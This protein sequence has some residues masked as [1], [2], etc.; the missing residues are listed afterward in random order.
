MRVLHRVALPGANHSS[1]ARAGCVAPTEEADE[2]VAAAGA[3]ETTLLRLVERREAGEPLAWVTGST[4]FLGHPV[5][6]R[7]G[8]YVPRWQTEALAERAIELLPPDGA[9]AD[10][11]TGSGSDRGGAPARSPGGEGGGHR[12]RP[13]GVPVRR[14]ERGRGLLRGP[15]RSVA[16]ELRGR[17]DV[18]VAVVPYVPT[19]AIAYLPTDARDHEP[20]LALDG[21]PDGTAVLRRAVAAASEW[22]RPKGTLLLELGGDQDRLL[23]ESLATA[24]FG[25]SRCH[26]DDEGDLRGLEATLG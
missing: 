18:V 17:L 13:G 4:R 22:L 15:G 14:R 10:L 8:V 21:G 26:H 19:D 24:G 5:V 20:P 25:A 23:A 1:R 7:P 6:V 3:D 12:T 16:P 2:L 11:C 9:A